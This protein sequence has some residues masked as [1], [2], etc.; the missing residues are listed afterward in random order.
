MVQQANMI[1]VS[2]STAWRKEADL[3]LIWFL[4]MIYVYRQTFKSSAE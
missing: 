3:A 4:V 2:K 1:Y